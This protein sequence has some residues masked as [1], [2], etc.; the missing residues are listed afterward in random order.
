MPYYYWSSSIVN[1]RGLFSANFRAKRQLIV[2]SD[3]A[4][5]I[6]E[7]LHLLPYLSQL[8]SSGIFQ[9]LRRNQ[10]YLAFKIDTRTRNGTFADLVVT[11]TIDF[12]SGSVINR[13]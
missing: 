9:V 6:R 8:V 13:D 7:I 4:E 5:Q 2:L 11:F 12:L 10:S 1:F 3:R